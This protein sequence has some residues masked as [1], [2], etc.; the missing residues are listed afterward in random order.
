MILAINQIALAEGLALG[1]SLGIDPVLLHGVINSS[2]GEGV[3][4]RCAST[5][6]PADLHRS[7]VVI[8]S[9]HSAS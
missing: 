4:C 2:S 9:E 3:E 7:I 6:R 1:R 8:E 5:A